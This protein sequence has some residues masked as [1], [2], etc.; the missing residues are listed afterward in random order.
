MAEEALDTKTWAGI[1]VAGITALGV[2]FRKTRKSADTDA[3]GRIPE[4]ESKI[5]QLERDRVRLD[6]E[7][8]QM[9]TTIDT[10]QTENEVTKRTVNRLKIAHD[11]KIDTLKE[12][13]DRCGELIEDLARLVRRQSPQEMPPS[14]LT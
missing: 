3:A 5:A 1:V 4:L 7:R 8:E 9:Q 11:E 2:F 13:V 10:M 14:R 6:K 12:S